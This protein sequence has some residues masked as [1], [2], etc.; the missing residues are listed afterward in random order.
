MGRVA[1]EPRMASEGRHKQEKEGY[2]FFLGK[3]REKQSNS[4][5]RVGLAGGEA[6]CSL[7]IDSLFW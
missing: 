4:G 7:S 2:S 6:T 3:E 5:N 1:V